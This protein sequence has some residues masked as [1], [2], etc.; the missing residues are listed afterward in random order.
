MDSKTLPGAVAQ[1]IAL[2]TSPQGNL[3]QLAGLISHDPMLSARVLQLANRVTYASKLGTVSSIT[4]AVRH[5]GFSAVRN[6]ASTIGIFDTMPGAK[7]DG[8]SPVRCWQH[9]LAV[10]RLCEHL[11]AGVKDTAGSAYLTGLCHDL[12]EIIFKTHFTAEYQQVLETQRK[13]GERLDLLERQMLGMTH[14]DLVIAILGLMGLPDAVRRPIEVMYSEN[15]GETAHG[16]RAAAATLRIANSYANGLL[17]SSS[18]KSRVAPMTRAALRLATGQG[19]PTLPGGA[20]FRS[21]IVGMTLV[22]A[23]LSAAEERELITPLF[24]RKKTKVW[25]A[26]DAVYSTFCPVAAALESMA[27]VVIHDRLPSAAEMR[28]FQGLVIVAPGSASVHFGRE[29]IEQVGAGLGSRLLWLTGRVTEADTKSELHPTTWP[30]SL[31]S[32]A[33]YVAGLSAGGVV[34]KVAAA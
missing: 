20:E 15:E 8:F 10:A 18:E 12:G 34:K 13:T 14:H 5:I 16:V 32:L 9:S 22:L 28:G 1:V 6:I 25:L 19:D 11:S 29:Q 23:R 7:S 3:P 24:P 4:D 27:E 2:A 17:L 26:R 31:E 33:A 21:E 30:I